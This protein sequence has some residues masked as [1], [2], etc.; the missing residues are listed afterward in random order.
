MQAAAGTSVFRLREVGSQGKFG[1]EDPSGLAEYRLQKK[2]QKQEKQLGD[3]ATNL[4]RN[5][6][7][8]NQTQKW[9][10]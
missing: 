1:A 2:G 6:R 7:G 8:L 3:R 4:Q 10:Q 9:K 5:Y